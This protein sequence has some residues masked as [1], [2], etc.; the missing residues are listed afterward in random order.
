MAIKLKQE[1]EE[2]LIASIQRYFDANMEEG[3]GDLKAGLLLDFCLKELGPCIYNQ[4]I[5]DAQSAMQ[6]KLAELDVNCYEAE[7]VYWNKK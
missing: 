5:A 6:D 3:I 1:T 2:R 4:A 7:F